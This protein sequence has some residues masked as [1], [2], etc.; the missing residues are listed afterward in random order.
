[1]SYLFYITD[2]YLPTKF[3]TSTRVIIIKK[4][5]INWNNNLYVGT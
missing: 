3:F 5:I 4:P 1:M 2:N